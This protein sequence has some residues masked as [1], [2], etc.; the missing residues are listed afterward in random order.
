[1]LFGQ[2]GGTPDASTDM[3]IKAGLTHK[4]LK[5]HIIITASQRYMYMYSSILNNK[6]K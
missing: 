6:N 4:L 1:M 5:F 2:G 3:H